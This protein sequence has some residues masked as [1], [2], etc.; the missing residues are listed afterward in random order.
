MH[1]GAYS[2]NTCVSLGF[3]DGRESTGGP[4]RRW[5]VCVVS[6]ANTQTIVKQSF[7]YQGED[8]LQNRALGKVLASEFTLVDWRLS[9]RVLQSH[10]LIHQV[11]FGCQR[12][13]NVQS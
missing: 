12:S 3:I 7:S 13:T 11:F 8:R 1:T 9:F 10:L 6:E 5:L 2:V 4:T